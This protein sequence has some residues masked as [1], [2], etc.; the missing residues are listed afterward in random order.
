MEEAREA[1]VDAGMPDALV[2]GFLELQRWFDAGGGATVY[3]TVETVTGT[4]ARPL[5]RF[6]EDHAGAFEPDPES[7]SE[8]ESKSGSDSEFGSGSG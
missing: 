6:V 8:S 4:P 2:E 3:D 5:R 1:M 7:E